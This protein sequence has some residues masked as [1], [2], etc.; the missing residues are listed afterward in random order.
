MNNRTQNIRIGLF[1]L[2]GLALLWVTF[3][4]LNGGRVFK[5]KG[6]VLLAR[7]DNLK[8]TEGATTK[9][10]TYGYDAEHKLKRVDTAE[11]TTLYQY[12]LDGNCKWIGVRPALRNGNTEH[13][14]H[15][16]PSGSA[17]FWSPTR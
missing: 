13:G 4:S 17:F 12:D 2:L 16:S 9:S 10:E 7:F 15:G 14:T 8:I 11:A 3:A 5:Q 1:S 6:Y